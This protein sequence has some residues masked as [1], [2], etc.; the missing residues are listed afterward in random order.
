MSS[1]ATV[2]QQVVGPSWISVTVIPERIFIDQAFC[3]G[4]GGEVRDLALAENPD[5]PAILQ[6]A[7]VLGTRK[8][9]LSRSYLIRLDSM[10]LRTG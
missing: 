4:M 7:L 3:R 9:W 2:G 1:I 5:P 10:A 8:Q 6:A